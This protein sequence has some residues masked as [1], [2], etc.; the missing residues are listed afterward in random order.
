[1]KAPAF[2][3]RLS[4][5]SQAR[6]FPNMHFSD[7]CDWNLH[8]NPLTLLQQKLADDGIGYLDL[9]ETNPSA[10]G[11]SIGHEGLADAL[12][13]HDLCAYLPQPRGLRETREAISD[14]YIRNTGAACPPDQVHLTPGTSEAYAWVFKLLTNPGD[15]ILVPSPSYP[16]FDFLAGLEL[17][18]TQ[19]YRFRY[20]PPSGWRLDRDSLHAMLSPRTR[21]VVAVHPNN[22]TGAYVA[23][24]DL[25]YLARFCA[26]HDLALL[27]DEVFFHYRLD[28]RLQPLSSLNLRNDALIFTLDGI[29]KSLALPQMKLGWIVTRGPDALVADAL[30]R[31]DIIA[32]TYLPVGTPVQQALPRLLDHGA[33]LRHRILARCARNCAALQAIA[34]GSSSLSVLEPEGGWSVVLE[35]H[36]APDEEQV[37]LRL[38]RDH[39]VLLHP[40]FFFDFPRGTHL[41][42]SLLTPED[43]FAEGMTRVRNALPSA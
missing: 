19:P 42:A 17:V 30:A 1:V 34:D 6:S 26:E 12:A 43:R 35:L 28:D 13:G 29:S 21:A 7:R 22:P 4:I 18:R 36:D 27:V 20:Q 41:V 37:A 11:I 32:D 33:A 2:S 40:G 8:P 3:S 15:E 31:L 38:L 10:A 25:R 9:C 5:N 14:E 39:Q 16:L 24:D 23:E